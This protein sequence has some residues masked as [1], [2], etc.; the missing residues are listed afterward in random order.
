MRTNQRFSTTRERSNYVVCRPGCVLQDTA[1]PDDAVAADD[2]CRTFRTQMGGNNTETGGQP[3]R[4]GWKFITTTSNGSIAP[5]LA[6]WLSLTLS[7]RILTLIH[8][9]GSFIF[10]WGKPI[11]H[12]SFSGYWFSDLNFKFGYNK[13]ALGGGKRECLLNH[14]KNHLLAVWINIRKNISIYKASNPQKIIVT[15]LLISNATWEKC[16]LFR[17]ALDSKK[18]RTHG[19]GFDDAVCQ[20]RLLGNPGHRTFPSFA[21]ELCNQFLKTV[22]AE[23]DDLRMINIWRC[24]DFTAQKCCKANQAMRFWYI[25]VQNLE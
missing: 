11:R 19:C 2:H 25:S 8:V 17:V 23:L 7:P 18:K 5:S 4:W 1:P 15:F 12:S 10:I 16:A 3:A 20:R 13:K 22:L 24:E 21:F 14:D 9:I 6:S